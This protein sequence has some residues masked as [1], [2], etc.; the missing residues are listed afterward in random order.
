MIRAEIL[1]LVFLSD[2]G[3]ILSVLDELVGVETLLDSLLVEPR[4][5]VSNVIILL[6]RLPNIFIIRFSISVPIENLVAA[7]AFQ[8]WR[9]DGHRRQLRAGLQPL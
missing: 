7:K 3:H 1:P 4:V 2:I 8:F 6:L 5:Q 9:E